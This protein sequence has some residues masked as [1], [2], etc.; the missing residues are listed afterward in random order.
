MAALLLAV[1]YLAFI[2]LG[3]PDSLLGAGWPVMHTDLGVPLSYGGLVTMIISFGTVTSSLL[4]ERLTKG[5]STRYVTLLSVL[6]MVFALLG[7]S[8]ASRFWML[9]LWAVPYGLGAGS[10]DA[11]LNNYVALH[12]SSRHMSWLHCFWGVGTIVSPYVMSLALT[13]ATWQTGYR[14]VGLIQLAIAGVLVVTLPLWKVHQAADRSQQG[15]RILGLSGAMRIRGVPQL[16]LGFCG[17]CALESTCIL[18]TSSY[19][20]A[21]RGVSPERAAAFASLF[22]IGITGGRFLSGLVSNRL[23][24]RTMIRLGTGVLFL[25]VL[26]LLVPR[27][28][29]GVALAACVIIGLGCAPIYPSIIHATPANFGPENSQ[30][31]IGVQMASAYMGSTFA[32]PLFGLLSAKLGLGLLPVYVA[33]FGIMMIAMVERAFGISKER[34]KA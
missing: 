23:G 11:A 22:F 5:L 7:F 6:C 13:H 17:Y 16:L 28:P 10:I 29:E 15:G 9:C 20:I 14:A 33:C 1:I 31:I 2:S 4:S 3:L 30:A 26:L 12:Y 34:M 21:T 27:L 25:G 18:W 32:P 19:L 8:C 24:D